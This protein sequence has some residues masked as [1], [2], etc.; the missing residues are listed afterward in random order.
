MTATK[1]WTYRDT[2]IE[3]HPTGWYSAFVAG[4]GYL[5]ADTLKGIKEEILNTC[6]DCNQRVHWD[7]KRTRQGFICGE[8]VRWQS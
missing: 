2:T 7:A 5:K 3:R 8:C 4:R 1:T 6:I